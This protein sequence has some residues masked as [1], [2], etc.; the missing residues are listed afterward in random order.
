[1]KGGGVFQN[2]QNKA[3]QQTHKILFDWTSNHR[4]KHFTLEKYE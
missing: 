3:M 4:I 1:M 2:I